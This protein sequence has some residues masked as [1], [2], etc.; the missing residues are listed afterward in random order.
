MDS[1]FYKIESLLRANG[2][3]EATPPHK[4]KELLDCLNERLLTSFNKGGGR[5]PC[6]VLAEKLKDTAFQ[7]KDWVEWFSHAN[8]EITRQSIILLELIRLGMIPSGHDPQIVEDNNTTEYDSVDHDHDNCSISTS[9]PSIDDVEQTDDQHSVQS[10][11]T[12][13]TEH[14]ELVWKFSECYGCGRTNHAPTVE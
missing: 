6:V 7:P 12:D 5:N 2:Y 10:G 14:T 11:A 4:F 9:S 1:L 3:L 13:Q 8:E